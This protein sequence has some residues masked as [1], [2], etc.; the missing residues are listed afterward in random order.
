[1]NHRIVTQAGGVTNFCW[2]GGGIYIGWLLTRGTITDRYS[3]FSYTEYCSGLIM[4]TANLVTLPEL[5]TDF[6]IVQHIVQDKSVWFYH[7]TM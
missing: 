6:F 4:V 3:A 7:L 1:M 2:R 5:L